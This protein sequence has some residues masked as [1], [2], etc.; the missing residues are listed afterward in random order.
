MDCVRGSSVEGDELDPVRIERKEIQRVH[1]TL[2]PN[3]V[4][5]TK[6]KKGGDSNSIRITLKNPNPKEIGRSRG[7]SYQG[8]PAAVT[9]ASAGWSTRRRLADAREENQKNRKDKN[10]FNPFGSRQRKRVFH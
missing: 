9:T 2:N 7:K 5:E 4:I 3:R 1:R 8:F 10:G 6:E